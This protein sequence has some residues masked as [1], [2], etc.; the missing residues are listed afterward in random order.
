MRLMVK[1]LLAIAM[2]C[3]SLPLSGQ[4]VRFISQL[5]A[6]QVINGSTFSIEFILENADAD[7]FT[8]PDFSPFKII[9]GPSQS[10][11]SSF[12]NGVGSRSVGFGY[13]LQATRTGKF[14]IPGATVSVKGKQLKSNPVILEVLRGE[15]QARSGESPRIF[16]RAVVDSTQAYVGQQIVIRYKIYTQVNIENYNIITESNYDGCFAQALDTYKEPVLKEVVD[17]REYSTKVLRKVSVFPQQGGKIDIT[18]MVVQVGVPS[19][20]TVRR[21]LFS[22]F[23]LERKNIS[24]NGISLTV[25]SAH[26]QSSGDFSGAVGKFNVQY[27]LRPNQ[28]TTDDAISIVMKIVGNGDVKTIRPPDLDLPKGF[29]VFDPKVKDEKM[30]NATDSVRGEK[31]IE[32]L[33]IGHQPGN[34]R[35]RPSF[36]YFDPAQGAFRTVVDSFQ[37]SISQGSGALSNTS[38][39]RLKQEADDIVPLTHDLDLKKKRKPVYL[40]TWYIGAYV[41]PV[42]AFLLVSWRSKHKNVEEVISDPHAIA[43]E[44]LQQARKYMDEGNHQQFYE[45]AA[46]GLKQFI[47]HKLKIQASDLSRQKITDRLLAKGIHRELEEQVR[48]FI[49]KCDLALYAGFNDASTITATYDEAV[50]LIT[51]LNKVL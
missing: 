22:S 4:Q 11:R 26:D 37:V 35:L 2:L 5:D 41:I 6:R 1:Y 13:L 34:Y 9:S 21:G 51:E 36:T 23:G 17:G 42:L 43:R 10:Y 47:A 3:L 32:Y 15:E 45:E 14:T 16:I 40:Q 48:L 31:V 20:S 25:R 8:P 38:D 12:V 46:L 7:N 50:E 39:D 28:A 18:P 24:S 49:E 29:E 44:R 19:S 30:I 27:S 33:V